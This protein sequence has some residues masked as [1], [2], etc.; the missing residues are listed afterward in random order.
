MC[1]NQSPT[2]HSHISDWQGGVNNH[3][4]KVN[5]FIKF[6]NANKLYLEVKTDAKGKQFVMATIKDEEG[7]GHF[8]NRGKAYSAEGED[9]G[10]VWITKQMTAPTQQT[11][12]IPNLN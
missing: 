6:I 9:M 8:I 11:L 5:E 12:D 10:Y 4:T 2:A 3:M 7:K 1:L